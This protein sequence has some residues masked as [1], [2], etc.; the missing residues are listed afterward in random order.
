M[1]AMTALELGL[2][3]LI[4]LGAG[5]LGGLLGIGGSIIM[6]PG[7]VILFSDRG[8]EHQ[9]IFQ[10]AAMAVNV[11]VAVPAALRHR[12]EGAV[13]A[14]LFRILLPSAG[15]A[16][17]IGVLLSNAISGEWLR[18]LF[19]GFLF[20]VGYEQT[21]TLIRSKPEPAEKDARV[22]V[23]RGA[24]VGGAMGL[25]AG[26]LGVGGGVVATPLAQ[27]L[28]KLPLRQAIGASSAAMCLTAAV[29][30]TLKFWLLP[31]AMA[32]SEASVIDP[33]ITAGVIAIA[34]AIPAMLGAWLGARLTHL[35]PVRVVRSVLIVV[36]ALAAWR[37]S[38]ITF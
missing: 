1:G 14:D 27:L 24:I 38:G 25:V 8:A 5:S 37:M 11:A 22:T 12:M 32:G 17:I 2:I 36:L 16:I 10:A 19:A 20:Y 7:L 31:D 3:A 29:G 6:I 18:S 26:L 28:C 34:L 15:A 4:G 33:R 9:H 35:L 13:R 30:A 21:R 23:G